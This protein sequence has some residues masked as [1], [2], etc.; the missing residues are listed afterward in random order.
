MIKK[1]FPPVVANDSEVLILG[2]LPGDLS[3][4]L[5]QYYAHPRNRFWPL[6]AKLSGLSLTEVY[7]ERLK[8]LKTCRFALWDVAAEAVRSGSADAEIKSETPNDIATLLAGH[9]RI[10]TLAFN[11][12]KAETLYFRFFEP[13]GRWRCISLPSTSPANAGYSM[14]ALMEAWSVLI[15]H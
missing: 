12:K 1:S 3:I 10:H 15:P 11:G 5:Q 7:E 9:P 13:L 2:S 8:M 14:E 4:Q 6:M